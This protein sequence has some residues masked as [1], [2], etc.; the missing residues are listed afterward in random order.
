MIQDKNFKNKINIC[1]KLKDKERKIENFSD[2]KRK[3]EGEL[4]VQ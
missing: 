2:C 1:K 3:R 4:Q